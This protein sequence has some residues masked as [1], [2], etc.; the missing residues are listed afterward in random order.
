MWKAAWLWSASHEVVSE[1]LEKTRKV[2]LLDGGQPWLKHPC[3][4]TQNA[5]SWLSC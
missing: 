5:P 3:A 1:L 4:R 2:T